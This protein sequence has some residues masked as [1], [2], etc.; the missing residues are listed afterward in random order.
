MR[1]V[2]FD[3]DVCDVDTIKMSASIGGI[4]CTDRRNYTDDA[5]FRDTEQYL[6]MKGKALR[7]LCVELQVCLDA[8][9]EAERALMFERMAY[10]VRMANAGKATATAWTGSDSRKETTN[11]VFLFNQDSRGVFAVFTDTDD[12]DG[13]IDYY[14][15]DNQGCSAALWYC[16]GCDEVT[17][18]AEYTDLANELVSLGYN[19]RIGGKI[20]IAKEYDND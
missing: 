14:S 19:L 13:N 7:D 15:P 2:K 1:T 20:C 9:H 18:P 12:E 8:A 6:D 11:V 17:D 10:D 5:V 16:A 4:E 3:L